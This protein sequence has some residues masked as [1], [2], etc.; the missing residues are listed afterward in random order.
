VLQLLLAEEVSIRDLPTILESLADAAAHTKDA[1]LLAEWTRAGIPTSVVRP[2]LTEGNQL[3]PL[4]F[5]PATERLLREGF[6]RGESIGTLTLDPS[7]TRALVDAVLAA[8]ERRGAAPGRPALLCAQELRPHVRR[9]LERPIPHVGVLSFA[10]IPGAVTVASS[11]A[12]SLEPSESATPA[13]A[14]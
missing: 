6:Q 9:L 8:L 1:A 2:Y 14:R 12:V 7:L 4:I 3:Q 5:R 13:G 11:I 10:E